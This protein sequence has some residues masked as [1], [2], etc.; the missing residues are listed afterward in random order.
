MRIDIEVETEGDFN[1]DISETGP[2]SNYN[3]GSINR[4]HTILVYIADLI[5]KA[6][7][8]DRTYEI[9]YLNKQLSQNELLAELTALQ[10]KSDSDDNKQ[11]ALEAKTQFFNI[12]KQLEEEAFQKF[13]IMSLYQIKKHKFY[14]DLIN[15]FT[16]SF[17][18]WRLNDRC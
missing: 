5:K 16:D 1:L 12:I 9:P 13:P 17:L 3:P 7:G 8:Q 14:K 2:V 11:D 15:D 6:N 10:N 18:I 4:A